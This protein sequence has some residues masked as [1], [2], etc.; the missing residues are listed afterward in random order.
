MMS[1]RPFSIALAAALWLAG[2]AAGADDFAALRHKIR[3]LGRLTAPPAVYPAD[4]PGGS[5]GVRALFFDGVPYRGKPTRVFAWYGAPRERAGKAPGIVLV[6]GGGGTAFL[7]WVRKWNE[8]GFAAISIAVEGQTDERVQP[9]EKGQLT[10][11]RHEWAGPAR[12]GIYADTAEPLPDQWMYHAVAATVLANSLLRSLPE[13]DAAKVGLMGISW[14]GVITSTVAGIDS[15][16]AFAIPTYGCG[17]MGDVENQWGRAL[18]ENRVYR[19]AWDPLH[20]LPSARMPILWLTWLRDEHFPLTAQSASYRSAPGPRMVAVLPDMRHS[21]PAGWAPPD[22]YAFAEGVVRT[23]RPWLRQTAAREERG[24]VAVEFSTDKPIEA[25][26][27]YTTSETGFVG[28]R[29]W[30]GTGVAAEQS[31]GRVKVAAPL[32]PGTTAWFVNVRAGA[33][34]ASSDFAGR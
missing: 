24:R 32:P 6:Q 8:H 23:G 21:H 5:P 25:A 18:G 12:Q 4:R 28:H 29:K 19:A 27:L 30:T 13:V 15:R 22:S 34:T 3:D 9:A 7:E 2:R 10:W 26:V 31:G 17:A 14:G 1:C 16:F 11:K 20:W 33:L